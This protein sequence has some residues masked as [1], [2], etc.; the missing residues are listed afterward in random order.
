MIQRSLSLTQSGRI[1]DRLKDIIAG[2]DHGSVD[3]HLLGDAGGDSRGQ[4]AARAVGM[5]RVDAR[6]LN[7]QSTGAKVINPLEFD[8][9][10]HF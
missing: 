5:A 1:A 10:G 7:V 6:A 3:V 9:T 8:G 2:P 4:G